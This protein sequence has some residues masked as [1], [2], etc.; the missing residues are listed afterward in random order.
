FFPILKQD[1]SVFSVNK[2][3]IWLNPLLTLRKSLEADGN[4]SRVYMVG[5]I[6]KLKQ[7]P[8]PPKFDFI[9]LQPVVDESYRSDYEEIYEIFHKQKPEL[10]QRVPIN[11]TSCMQDSINDNLMF[12]II[13]DNTTI[14][15][16]AGEKSDLL[17][18]T[19]VYVSEILIKHNFKGQ[20]LAVSSQRKFIEQLPVEFWC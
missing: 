4:L 10:K 17:G 3:S 11:S 20:G 5:E 2:L 19:S 13:M 14:G 1:F 18:Q 7:N 16:I 8:I 6:S 15:Y 9:K 12:K